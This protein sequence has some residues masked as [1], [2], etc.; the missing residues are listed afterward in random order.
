MVVAN[1]T[2]A[3]API[4]NE[5]VTFSLTDAATG[6][7]AGVLNATTNEGGIAAVEVPAAA[8]AAALRVSATHGQSGA[9]TQGVWVPGSAQAITW[10]QVG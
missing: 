6:A 3:G 7:P 5:L 8:A 1:L 9:V 10:G 4:P 2:Q